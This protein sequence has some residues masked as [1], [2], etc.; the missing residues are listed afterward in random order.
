M[1]DEVVKDFKEEML[2]VSEEPAD[3]RNYETLRNMQYELPDGT[4]I[5]I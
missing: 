5:N 2:Y 1:K 4:P 3:E